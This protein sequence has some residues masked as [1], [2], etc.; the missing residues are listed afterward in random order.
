MPWNIKLVHAHD[1]IK[2]KATG[3]LDL[4]ASKRLIADLA[5]VTS[6]SPGCGLLVDLRETTSSTSTPVAET[7]AAA[8][9][10]VKFHDAF[11]GRKIAVMDLPKHLEQ[12]KLFALYANNHGM[13]V[14]PFTNFEDAIS[15]LTTESI[16]TPGAAPS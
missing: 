2:T 8:Q 1:F 11:H 16:L 9:E 14:G 4:E 5:S 12:S 6:S 7:Y 10:F 13:C 15:W 3:E